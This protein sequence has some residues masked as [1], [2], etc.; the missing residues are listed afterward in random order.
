MKVFKPAKRRGK[1]WEDLINVMEVVKKV[2]LELS[3]TLERKYEDRIAG[4][5]SIYFGDQF[6]DQRNTKQVMTRISL[7]NHDHRP[8]LSIDSDG[9]AI[10]VKIAK[11]GQSFREAI[12]Q[13]ILYRIGYRFVLIV[14]VDRTKNKTYSS[15]INDENS[16]E[17]KFIKDLE[18]ENIF[19]LL[20]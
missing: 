1:H 14:I 7:F 19:C 9:V 20:K 12:G 4:A 2:P 11:T 17:H 8:D 3:T 15:L 13:A 10:E 6:I 16:T 5:L 18:E